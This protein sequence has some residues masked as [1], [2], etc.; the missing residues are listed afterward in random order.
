MRNS[1]IPSS[2]HILCVVFPPILLHYCIVRFLI[3]S[4]LHLR[5]CIRSSFFRCC[6][7]KDLH[8]VKNNVH[9]CR[10]VVCV[11]CA[12]EYDVSARN[13]V[14]FSMH[15]S[16]KYIV[17]DMCLQEYIYIYSHQWNGVSIYVYIYICLC[18]CVLICIYYCV[19]IGV[20]MYSLVRVWLRL[21]ALGLLRFIIR[22]VKILSLLQL[23]M[24]ASVS[25]LSS[26]EH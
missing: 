17:L 22:N 16:R 15:V 26:W 7:A 6:T 2:P 19:C 8:R 10:H 25:K 12:F 9:E 23:T 11:T 20:N 14:H 21:C 3:V 24:A 4:S 13:Y 1:V 18:V 5:R